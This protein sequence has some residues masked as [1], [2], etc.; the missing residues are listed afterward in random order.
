MGYLHI[1]NLYKNQTVLMFRECYA[2]EKIHGTSA[3]LRFMSTAGGMDLELFPGGAS[4]FAF[5]AL[6]DK[7]A[8]TEAFVGLGANDEIA[9]YGEA[10]GGAMH[11]MKETYGPALKFVVF[12]VSIGKTWLSVPNAADV[13]QK[14]GLEFVYYEK[15]CANLAAVDA[16]RDRPSEQ[17]RRNGGWDVSRPSEGVILRPLLEFTDH[18]GNRVIAKHKRAD[19]SERASKRDTELSPE[20]VKA[21][22]GAQAI[23]DEWV[24]P[25]RMTHVADQLLAKLGRPLETADTGAVVRA[26]IEDVQREAAG[27]IVQ[28]R[29]ATRAIGGA[30]AK[31]FQKYLE[32]VLKG[33]A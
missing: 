26:M 27:E 13:A 10:Y 12:D 16:A 2:L 28:S 31:Q 11:R 8:L 15:I 1:D 33:V 14:L 5:A 19:F 18:R 25:M 21:L 32:N 22:A 7:Q 6:F 24:T 23:A 20:K 30:A 9:V 17:A 3:H 29:E 4:V